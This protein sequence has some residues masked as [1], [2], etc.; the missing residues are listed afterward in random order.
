VVRA[1]GLSARTEAALTTIE[2]ADVDRVMGV[3][4]AAVAAVRARAPHV[5]L[6]LTAD[7]R[8]NGSTGPHSG[9]A[10]RRRDGQ[11][12]WAVDQ[13]LPSQVLDDQYRPDQLP[14]AQYRPAQ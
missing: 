7:L 8:R 4:D 3:V 11:P 1:S 13:V 5:S 2:S 9:P 6:V 14:P 12:Q 10:Q